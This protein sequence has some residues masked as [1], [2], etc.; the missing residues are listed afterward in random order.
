MI[1]VATSP[2]EWVAKSMDRLIHRSAWKG[3]SQ[4]S[5]YLIGPELIHVLGSLCT[6]TTCRFR[7][8]GVVG[9][10]SHPHASQSEIYAR[11][12]IRSTQNSPSR[13]ADRLVV[14]LLGARR[15]FLRSLRCAL[16][17]A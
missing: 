4:K 11:S 14:A 15:L 1:F 7:S 6:T 12:C 2:D 9:L 17:E 5:G 10:R 13:A 16:Q 3:N 8:R